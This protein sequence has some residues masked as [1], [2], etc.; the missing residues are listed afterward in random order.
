MGKCTPGPWTIYHEYNVVGKGDR[1]VAAC[2]GYAAFPPD[3]ETHEV[4]AR[5][6]RLIAAAPEMLDAL[7]G[8]EIVYAEYMALA[9][10]GAAMDHVMQAVRDARAAI[11]K[12]TGEG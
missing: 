5:N 7:S 6:A 9:K 12:A 2:G 3:K 8:I 11:R 10:P 1:L 4:N